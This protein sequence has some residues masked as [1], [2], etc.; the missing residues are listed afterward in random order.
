MRFWVGPETPSKEVSP[1]GS[2]CM[3]PGLRKI[4][5]FVVWFNFSFDPI[6]T[7]RFFK[8]MPEHIFYQEEA[9]FSTTNH[10]KL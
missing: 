7:S 5:T 3:G 8:N 1:D 4:L 6:T 2:S 10:K 9:E